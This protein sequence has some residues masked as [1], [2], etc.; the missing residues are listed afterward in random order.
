MAKTDSE[1]TL[2]WDASCVAGDDDY[3][4]YEGEGGDFTSHTSK[5]CTTL[6]ATSA[7]FVPAAGSSYYL[8][9]P[10]NADREGSYGTDSNGIERPQGTDLP[11]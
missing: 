1:I 7:T 2:S 4:I 3:E 10:R 9:V 11:G 5:L 6:G 8:V